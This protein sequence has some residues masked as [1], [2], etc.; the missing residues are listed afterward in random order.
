MM[1]ALLGLAALFATGLQ[2]APPAPWR[3]DVQAAREAAVREK[4]PCVLLL[5]IDSL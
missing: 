5:F 3:T 4:K 1:Q 2:D